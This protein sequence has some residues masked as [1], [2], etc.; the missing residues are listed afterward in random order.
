[1]QLSL[2]LFLTLIL[3]GFEFQK[4]KNQQNQFLNHPN[5]KNFHHY[6]V[7]YIPIL[8][9]GLFLFFQNHYKTL[10]AIMYFHHFCQ[11]ILQSQYTFVNLN[12]QLEF[13]KSII[14]FKVIL[15]IFE[16]LEGFFFEILI[17][18]FIQIKI[19]SNL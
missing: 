5:L 2:S 11:I 15:K 6:T 4:C 14:F 9:F 13:L 12:T 16:I 3:K 18:N 7:S 1:M 17:S 10:C 8:D 19:E